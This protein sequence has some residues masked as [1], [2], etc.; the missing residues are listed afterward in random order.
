MKKLQQF[1]Q[2]AVYFWAIACVFFIPFPFHIFP[3][4]AGISEFLWGRLI[5][6]TTQKILHVTSITHDISSDSL[7]MYVLV[8][9]LA[10]LAIAGASLGGYLKTWSQKR[11]DIL[12]VFRQIFYYYLALQMLKYGFDKVF[13]AQF[14]LPEPNTL[15]TPLG[16]L[17]KDIMF[18]S[19]MGTSYTYTLF[20]GVLEVLAGAC[21]LFKRTRILGLLVTTGI[22]LNVVAINFGFDISVKIYSL[23]LLLLSLTLLAPQAT[24]LY[25][26]L[27]LQQDSRLRA[28]PETFLTFFN[29]TARIIAQVFVISIILLEALYPYIKSGNFNDDSWPRPY[30][31]G[32]YQVI[33]ASV[34]QRPVELHQAPIK[35]LF[36]HRQGF[37][38]FQ[39]FEDQMQDFR[40]DIR[41]NSQQILL[42]DY[43]LKQIIMHY[44]YQPKDSLLTLQYTQENQRIKLT[45]KALDWRKLPAIQKQFHWSIDEVK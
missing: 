24:R 14:Y 35:R 9:L 33:K 19:T 43:S 7:R 26:F 21:I 12:A 5:D 39:N 34:D 30:L 45:A 32:A 2:D 15:Y 6:F 41:Q 8:L 20:G 28:A 40:L 38:I 18:W 36:V 1:T 37:M 44:H 25:Q 11:L 29:R 17:S 27:I 22:M 31:H 23:L 4:Q 16:Q 13:K 42:T 10:I 3:F